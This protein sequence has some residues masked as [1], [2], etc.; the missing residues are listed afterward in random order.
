MNVTSVSVKTSGFSI[1]SITQQTP[2]TSLPNQTTFVVTLT[3]SISDTLAI[4]AFGVSNVY[5]NQPLDTNSPSV[6]SGQS[7]SLSASF[8][9]DYL[10]DMLLGFV[11]DSGNPSK[12]VGSCFTLVATTTGFPSSRTNFGRFT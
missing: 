6:A 11:S 3:G 9:T 10:N 1:Q 5:R 12:T 8:S 2:F 7:T 4:V